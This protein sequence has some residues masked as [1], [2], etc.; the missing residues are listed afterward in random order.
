MAC[1]RNPKMLARI[2]DK[3]MLKAEEGDIAAVRELGDRLDG[4]AIQAVEADIQTYD[5]GSYDDREAVA[6]AV[7]SLLAPRPE[8][9]ISLEERPDPSPLEIVGY[10]GES[11]GNGSGTAM[12]PDKPSHTLAPEDATSDK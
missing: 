1:K 12:E 7:A 5:A 11:P 9:E 2:A 6:K 8:A 4:K 10:A 3:M